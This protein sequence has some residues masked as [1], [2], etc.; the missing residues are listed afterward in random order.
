[1][2]MLPRLLPRAAALDMI[3]SY[4]S[5]RGRRADGWRRPK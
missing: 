2:S 4:Q 5:Q 3:G 1:M